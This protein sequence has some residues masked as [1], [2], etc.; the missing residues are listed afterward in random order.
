[1]P[2]E[3]QAPA[4]PLLAPTEAAMGQKAPGMAEEGETR[5]EYTQRRTKEYNQQLRADPGNVLLWRQYIEFQVGSAPSDV[6][7]HGNRTLAA[8][9]PSPC[10]FCGSVT[11]LCAGRCLPAGCRT[12]R[13]P[14]K[15]SGPAGRKACWS[16]RRWPSSTRPCWRIRAVMTYGASTWRLAVTNSVQ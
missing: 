6:D 9:R 15:T 10:G 16:R 3:V 8:R 11:L 14:Q 5:L 4:A 1:M 7:M 12:K 2:L 13:L